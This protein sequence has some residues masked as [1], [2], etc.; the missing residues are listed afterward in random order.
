MGVS[1]L[2]R[3]S[4]QYSPFY[5]GHPT[6]SLYTLDSGVRAATTRCESRW[7]SE[8]SATRSLQVNAYA[9]YVNAKINLLAIGTGKELRPETARKKPIV[10]SVEEY[11]RDKAWDEVIALEKVAREAQQKAEKCPD[12]GGILE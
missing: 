6:P 11:K 4:R 5:S 12:Y 2:E 9:R 7:L 1:K 8:I 3:P 10:E